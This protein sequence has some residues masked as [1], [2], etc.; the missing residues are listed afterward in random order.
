MK[1]WNPCIDRK[2]TE[3][4]LEVTTLG[5][6]SKSFVNTMLALEVREEDEIVGVKNTYLFYYYTPDHMSFKGY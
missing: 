5:D 1:K 4:Y 2:I 3:F 6:N